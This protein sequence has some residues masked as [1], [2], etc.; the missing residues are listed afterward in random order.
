[1]AELL[2]LWANELAEGDH[3]VNVGAVEHIGRSGVFVVLQVNV[4]EWT[5]LD[6]R[7]RWHE[8]T[9]VLHE[10][11]ETWVLRDAIPAVVS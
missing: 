3:L 9:L 7:G 10:A 1:M 4:Q 2:E 6:G 5:P 11:T 8:T